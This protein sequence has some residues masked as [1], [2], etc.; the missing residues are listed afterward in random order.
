M[1]NSDAFRASLA[2]ILVAIQRNAHQALKIAVDVAEKSAKD[3]GL[4]TSRTGLLRALTKGSVSAVSLTGKLVSAAPYARFVED[5]TQPHVISVK[6][7]GS[8]SFVSGGQRRF[9]RT[10]HHPGTA[11]RP[12]M[13]VARDLGEQTLEYALELATEAAVKE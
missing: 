10:V 9:A 5:G 8:L 1:I 13:Q 6:G 3:S 4:Y 7:G 12:F 11:P 2:A